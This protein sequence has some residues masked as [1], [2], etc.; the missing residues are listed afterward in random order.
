MA[1]LLQVRDGMNCPN[2]TA[3]NYAILRP[4]VFR[5][6]SLSSVDTHCSN[7]EREAIGILH[8]LQKCYH[9]LKPIVSIFEKGIATLS[10]RLQCILLQIHQYKIC[11]IYKPGPDCT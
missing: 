5:S 11:K 2:D 1:G 7:K 10:Q 9:Y 6:R 8:G 3:P 4:I